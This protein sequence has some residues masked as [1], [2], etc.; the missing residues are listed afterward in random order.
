MVNNKISSIIIGLLLFITII[1]P[2]F[3][4]MIF[5]TKS[6]AEGL[7]FILVIHILIALFSNSIRRKIR[8]L[9]NEF[10]LIMMIMCIVLFHGI[11]CFIWND[12]FDLLRFFHTYI[13]LLFFLL[14]ALMFLQSAKELT[15]EKVDFTLNFVFYMLLMC[16]FFG[17]FKISPFTLKYAKPIVFFIEP[18]HFALDFLPFLL[19]M[20]LSLFHKFSNNY[21]FYLILLVFLLGILLQS[22]TLLVGTSLIFL[23]SNPLKKFFFFLITMSAFALLNTEKMIFILSYF[24]S[25]N[26]SKVVF[27]SGFKRIYDNL[28]ETFGFG[29]Q[30]LGALGVNNNTSSLILSRYGLAD[31]NLHDGGFV[32][33][34]LISEFGLLGIILIIFYALFF[35]RIVIYLRRILLSKVKYESSLDIFFLSCYVMYVIDL[36]FR[37]TGYFSST[38]FLFI[39]SLMW[40]ISRKPIK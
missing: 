27:L 5:S 36:F 22:F 7:F 19:Y 38:G 26:L 35:F 34:K 28:K 31:L 1:L 25:D 40:L 18:S 4:L 21:N 39:A 14:G 24:S 17:A 13:F 23:I 8:K 30:Q 32:A 6:M 16:A 10:T 29:F 33:V 11:Q 9:V 12:N 20:S 3:V 15:K 2:S 37:G